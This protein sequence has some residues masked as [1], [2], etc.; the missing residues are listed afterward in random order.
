MASGSTLRFSVEVAA[1]QAENALKAMTLAFNQAEI[2]AKASLLG[3]GKGAKESAGGIEEL[4]KS[5]GRSRETAMFFTQ[6]LGEFGPAGRTAQIAVSGIAGAIMGGGGILLALSLAQAGVRLLVDSWQEDAKQAEEA[7]KAH[8]KAAEE[9][10]KYMAALTGDANS[11]LAELGAMRDSLAGTTKA[12]EAHNKVLQINQD[13]ALAQTTGN[14]A[15]IRMLEIRLKDAKAIE[16]QIAG[17]E[18]KALADKA[19]EEATRKKAEAAKA[20]QSEREKIT[21]YAIDQAKA[22]ADAEEQRQADIAKVGAEINAAAWKRQEEEA[23]RIVAREK[24][25]E[26]DRKASIERQVADYQKVGEAAGSMVGGLI[27]G[28]MTL[29]QVVAQTGQMVIQSVIQTAIAS[30]TAKAADAAAGAA[31]S[32]SVIPVFGPVLAISAMGAMLSAVMGLLGNMPSA[33]GGWKVPHDTLAM[34]HEDERILPAKYSAGLDRLVNQGG[35]SSSVV[36]NISATD[37]KS[38]RRLLLDNQPALAEAIGRALRDGRRF[39]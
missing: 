28:Q 2:K 15:Q 16:A 7:A 22:E 39:A 1:D 35:S 20:Y 8:K 17:L 5:M 3:I 38:V 31:A 13:L 24:K 33:A 10:Q 6:A 18:K 12:Q 32:Q 36:V 23:G 27:T 29:A 21:S 19:E 25:E 34:V 26:V 4:K 37:P 9:A 14:S 11:K 30:V